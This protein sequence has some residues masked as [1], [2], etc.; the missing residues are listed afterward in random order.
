MA[1]IEMISCLIVLFEHENEALEIWQPDAFYHLDEI[2]KSF[3]SPNYF[4]DIAIGKSFFF[5]LG[6]ME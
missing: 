6:K 1:I 5:L 4:G 2:Q 3:Y